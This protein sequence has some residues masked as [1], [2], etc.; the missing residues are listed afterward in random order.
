LGDGALAR[1]ALKQ[2]ADIRPG[3]ACARS[4]GG[5]PAGLD[6]LMLPSEAK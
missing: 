1:E 3:D 6:R 4:R 2:I 5:D